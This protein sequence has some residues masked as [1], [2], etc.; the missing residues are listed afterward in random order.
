MQF[1]KIRRSTYLWT[2]CCRPAKYLT[3]HTS[4]CNC[5]TYM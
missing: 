5:C 1:S 3:L 4:H 2:A